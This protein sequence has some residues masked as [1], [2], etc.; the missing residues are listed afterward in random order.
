MVVLFILVIIKLQG[1]I[2]SQENAS[3]IAN[4]W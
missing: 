1:D 4:S 2:I 3:T